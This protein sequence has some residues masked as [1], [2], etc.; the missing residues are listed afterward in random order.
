MRQSFITPRV[1]K[2]LSVELTWLLSIFVLLMVV[3]AG[4]AFFLDR[5]ITDQRLTLSET[6]KSIETLNHREQEAKKEIERLQRLEKMRESVSTVNRLKKEN[7]KNFFDLVPE[8]VVLEFA[9]LRDGTLRLKGTTQSPKHF[10]A[11]FQRSLDSLFSRSST[12]F[13]RLKNGRY[14]FNSISF[15][16]VQK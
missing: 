13:K 16:E 1:K 9:E 3:M 7:V 2:V 15:S 14:R 11:T 4:S 12:K 6:K 10:R 5:A 8:G